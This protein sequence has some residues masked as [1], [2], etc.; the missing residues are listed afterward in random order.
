MA[1]SAP[2]TWDG[3]ETSHATYL[4]TMRANNDALWDRLPTINI[5]FAGAQLTSSGTGGQKI[6]RFQHRLRYLHYHF[7]VIQ[8]TIDEV[9]LFVTSDLNSL[10]TAYVTHGGT[11]NGGDIMTSAGSDGGSPVD[12]NA[13]TVGTLYWVVVR[14]EIASG[15]GRVFVRNLYESSEA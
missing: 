8:S 12:L 7:D 2:R 4:Q 1:Y 5:G 9:K 3:T 14:M 15:G 11:Y 10:G 13:L 6:W